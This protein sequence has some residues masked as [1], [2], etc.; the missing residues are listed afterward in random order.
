MNFD[1][2]LDSDFEIKPALRK[3]LAMVG[4]HLAM[5]VMNLAMNLAMKSPLHKHL[6]M[7]AMNLLV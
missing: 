5:L 7:L 2:N 1:L 6:A 3:H 4:K